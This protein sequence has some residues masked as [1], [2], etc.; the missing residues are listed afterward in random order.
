MAAAEASWGHIQ[1]MILHWAKIQARLKHCS[2]PV[3]TGFD[4][5][6]WVFLFCFFNGLQN[7]CCGKKTVVWEVRLID[8]EFK[9]YVLAGQWRVHPFLYVLASLFRKLNALN[10]GIW[11]SAP[12]DVTKGTDTSPGLAM[13]P[14]TPDQ[15]SVPPSWGH[16][17]GSWKCFC[18]R[19]Q[20]EC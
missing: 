12:C 8:F 5:R 3:K 13:T 18:R 4:L 9:S 16:L 15:V 10:A 14:P 7:L 19:W 11:E 17:A 2:G 20:T 1:Y 6:L